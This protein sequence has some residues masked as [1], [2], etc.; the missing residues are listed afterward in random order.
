WALPPVPGTGTS[1]NPKNGGTC[2]CSE[3]WSLISTVSAFVQCPEH[4]LCG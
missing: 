4:W 3:H 2:V 1:G